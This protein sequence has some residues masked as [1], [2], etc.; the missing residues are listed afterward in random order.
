VPRKTA[1]D[2]DQELLTLFDAY[3][4]G[5]LDRRG[6]LERAAKYAAAGATAQML[7]DELSP[8]FAEAQVV[9]PDD[10][11]LHTERVEIASPDGYGTIRALLARPAGA[12]GRLSRAGTGLI[13][14]GGDWDG[15]STRGAAA[16][17]PGRGVIRGA[18]VTCCR[19]AFA[20]T[21][22]TA[23]PTTINTGETRLVFRPV[24]GCL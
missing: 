10:E 21:S 5:D 4:H 22:V 24:E 3:V 17:G 1:H 16:A 13:G 23:T 19:R 2:Y 14:S 9:P 12:S 8:R 11:R 20:I 18:K 6:F 7:L 15:G